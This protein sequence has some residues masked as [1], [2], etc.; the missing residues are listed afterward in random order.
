MRN[1]ERPKSHGVTWKSIAITLVLIPFNFY[2]IIAGEV[3]LVGYALNTYAVPFYNVVFVVFAFTLLNLAARRRLF[4]DAE[5]LTIYILLSTACAFPSITLMTILVTTVGHAFWFATPENEWLS[6]FGNNIPSWIAVKSPRILDGFY[7]GDSTLYN[8]AT[9]DAWIPPVLAW[10]SFVIALWLTLLA[11]TIFLRRQ[12]TENE[13]L[14]YPIVQLPLALTSNPK[15]F[16]RSPWMWVG[17]AVAGSVEL[18]NGLSFLFPEIPSLPIRNRILGQFSS[19]PWSA[20]GPIRI[21]FYPFSIGLMFF[22]P[23]DLSFSCW[24]FWLLSRIQLIVTDAFGAR[25]IYHL[26]QQTGAWIAFGCIPLWMGRRHYGRILR[27]VFGIAQRSG[28]P[29]PDDSGEPMRYRTAAGLFTVGLMFLFFFC[30][31]MGMTFWAIGLF[32]LFYFPL[33]IGITRIRAEIGPPLH[34]LIFVDPGRTMVLALGTRRLGAANLTG[35]TFLYPFVRC[36]RAHPTPSELEAFRLAERSQ[37]GYR[38]LLIGMILAIVFGILITFWAYLHVLYDMGAG[39]KAR[40][41]IVYM[42]WETFNRLQTWLV[43]P[44]ETSVPELSVIGSSFMFTIFLMIMKVRFLWWPLHPGGYVLVSGTGM[45]RLWFT[46]FLS[47]LAKAIV[48][49]I[50]G[51]KLYR[52]AVPFFLGLILGDYTLGCVWSLIGLVLEIPTY[53]VWH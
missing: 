21:S 36:F 49:K 23:L 1:D 30:F 11:V 34:Q 47:W 15:R 2:W 12:W 22:T 8:S 17:F 37:I 5:L 4:T 13:R 33:V 26:E 9:L 50:G 28:E 10:S 43:S 40:G 14:N 3:G 38:Q 45:G 51:V 20:M 16:F 19:K 35:L 6:L 24:F 29:V 46:I 41:W 18:L 39:S 25:N 32:F 53:I 48:L 27:K 7:N 31:Q 42:G 44:R 52:Q